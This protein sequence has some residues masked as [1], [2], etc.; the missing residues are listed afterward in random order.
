M[1]IQSKKL[2]KFLTKQRTSNKRI[3]VHG[4][5][6]YQEFEPRRWG[7]DYFAFVHIP[8]RESNKENKGAC[9]ITRVLID[10]DERIIFNLQCQDC[11]TVNALKTTPDFFNFPKGKTLYKP[12]KKMFLINTKYKKCLTSRV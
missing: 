10:R 12:L 1:K 3:L 4:I 11:K 2:N 6:D 5:P 7:T 9:D 8:C